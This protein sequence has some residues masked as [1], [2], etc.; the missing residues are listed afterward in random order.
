MAC[1]NCPASVCR[2][3]YY[4]FSPKQPKLCKFS[5]AND[6][7]LGRPD[8]LLSQANMTHEMCLALARTVATKV[9]LRAGGAQQNGSSNG[10]Q[11]DAAFHQS[12][13]VGSSVLFHNGD[14]RHAVESLPPRQLNDAMAITFCTDL[15]HE[16]QS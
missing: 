14:A 7:W 4:A 9:V 1:G 6:L 3:C 10:N 15:P 16:G 2:D 8:P 11:W 5:L 12:G 13:Y